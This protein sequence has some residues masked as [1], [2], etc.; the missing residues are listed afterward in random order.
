MFNINFI[1]MIAFSLAICYGAVLSFRQARE[2][3]AEMSRSAYRKK[4]ISLCFGVAAVL[5]CFG[6]WFLWLHYDETKP[7]MADDSVGRIYS[8]GNHGHVV[9]L[10]FTE[11]CCLFLLGT[12]AFMAF[13]SSFILDRRARKSLIQPEP[14]STRQ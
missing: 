7:T 6:F 5:I 1:F 12:V 4:L 3:R 11:R 13:L 14:D 2:R 8:I 9:F 10:T